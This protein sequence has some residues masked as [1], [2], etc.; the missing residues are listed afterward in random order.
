MLQ[1]RRFA[2]SL[3]RLNG[4]IYV[5]TSCL[6]PL[7]HLVMVDNYTSAQQVRLEA[8]RG[9]VLS[10]RRS[11]V[12][13]CPNRW[14]FECGIPR[15][16]VPHHAGCSAACT[17]HC[18]LSLACMLCMH[19]HMLCMH[20]ICLAWSAVALPRTCTLI[21]SCHYRQAASAFMATGTVF[22]LYEGKPCSDGGSTSGKRM[23]PL[24]QDGLRPQI[25][26][27]PAM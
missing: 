25:T 27:T 11:P 6:E 10:L 20:R 22:E 24:F 21:A 3:G 19:P 1:V 13:C 14:S 7:P 17:T 18:M 26:V 9:R 16:L 15:M 8:S 5:G 2:A 12:C 23:T 4:V